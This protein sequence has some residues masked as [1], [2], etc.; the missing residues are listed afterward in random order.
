MNDTYKTYLES[1]AWAQKRNKRLGMSNFKCEACEDGECRNPLQVHHLTYARIFREEMEDLMVLCKMHHAAAE[2]M[3]EKGALSR[4]GN[5]KWLRS[6][7]LRFIA[8]KKKFREADK[9]E[10]APKQRVNSEYEPRRTAANLKVEKQDWPSDIFRKL[11]LIPEV[12]KALRMPYKKFKNAMKSMFRKHPSKQ[13]IF[14]AIYQKH[15]EFEKYKRARAES[16]RV[17]REKKARIKAEYKMAHGGNSRTCQ[18]GGIEPAKMAA[19]AILKC[20]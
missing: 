11:C 20:P 17:R 12:Q 3:V 15:P 2:E 5:V 8:P 9:K 4:N 6:E 19:S 13:R 10:C 14:S 1:E 7:T 16:R 18:N